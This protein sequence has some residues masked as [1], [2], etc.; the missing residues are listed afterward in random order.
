MFT[1]HIFLC[2]LLVTVL[3]YT[4]DLSWDGTLCII[5]IIVV[6]SSSSFLAAAIFVFK[7]QPV[8]RHSWSNCLPWQ[9]RLNQEYNMMEKLW[10]VVDQELL[11]SSLS[12]WLS[13]YMEK[14]RLMKFLAH[15]YV[16]SVFVLYFH[17]LSFISA[18]EYVDLTW[19][20][21]FIKNFKI[22]Q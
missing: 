19:K 21:Y 4:P 1:L 6:L 5:A 9:L 12:R 13:N 2:M 16:V 20:V 8:I 14:K 11:W 18:F 15:W 22:R 7:R 10:Q 17:W 3:S